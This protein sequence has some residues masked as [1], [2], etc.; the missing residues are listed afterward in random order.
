MKSSLRT[1]LSISAA[2]AVL[3]AAV[4]FL[5]TPVLELRAAGKL[6]AAY[7][8][9]RRERAF[10]IS[11]RHSVARLPAIEY[12]REGPCGELEL[13]KTAYQGLGAGLP[14]TE[15]GGTVRL[16]GGWILI[17]DLHRRFPSVTLSPMPLT[18]HRLLVGGREVDLAALSGGRSFSLCIV[19]RSLIARLVL[20]RRMRYIKP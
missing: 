20:G 5:R 3:A 7:T 6:L 1:W 14:F 4:F 17:E 11:Y 9:D 10:Q 16:E 13:Y 8:L 19:R 2:A 18:E 12:F 15:E